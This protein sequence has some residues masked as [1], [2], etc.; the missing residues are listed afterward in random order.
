MIKGENNVHVYKKY[1][2]TAVMKEIMLNENGIK[3]L[4][5]WNSFRSRSDGNENVS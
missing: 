5:V 3:F 2:D 4:N 1:K